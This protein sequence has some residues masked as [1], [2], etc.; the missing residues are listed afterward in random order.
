MLRSYFA[1]PD[2]EGGWWW[3][4]KILWLLPHKQDDTKKQKFLDVNGNNA[5]SR[6]NVLLRRKLHKLSVPFLDTFSFT[7]GMET[8][9]LDGCH[10]SQKV[11]RVKAMY[12]LNYLLHNAK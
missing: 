7:L 1:S 3:H 10:Y 9:T 2:G 6:L 12:I 5:L 4:T 11:D 8:E